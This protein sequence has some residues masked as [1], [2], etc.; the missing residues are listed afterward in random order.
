MTGKASHL[1]A[2]LKMCDKKRTPEFAE[3]TLRAR[4]DADPSLFSHGV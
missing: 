3:P 4:H 1:L 2:R